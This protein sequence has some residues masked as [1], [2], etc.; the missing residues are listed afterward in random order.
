MWNEL[1]W[2]WKQNR[3]VNNDES[4]WN[5]VNNSQQKGK[6]KKIEKIDEG[7]DANGRWMMIWMV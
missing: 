5:V 2:N 6:K 1:K 4:G 7:I 3:F